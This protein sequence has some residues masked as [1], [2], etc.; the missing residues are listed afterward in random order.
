MN[1]DKSDIRLTSSCGLM[2]GFKQWLNFLVI[3]LMQ[4]SGFGVG[5]KNVDICEVR[6]CENDITHAV[7]LILKVRKRGNEADKKVASNLTFCESNLSWK[8]GSQQKIG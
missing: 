2:N 5:V 8:R 4:R 7:N 3:Q 6:P 1:G